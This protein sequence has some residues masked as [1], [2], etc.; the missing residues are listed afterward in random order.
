MKSIK[1]R[2]L[3]QADF[4][5]WIGGFSRSRITVIE[6]VHEC[7]GDVMF[8]LCL[9]CPCDN[10]WRSWRASERT[11]LNCY[12]TFL[13]HTTNI[14]RKVRAPRRVSALGAPNNVLNCHLDK[15][16]MDK[17]SQHECRWSVPSLNVVYVSSVLLLTLVHQQ[18]HHPAPVHHHHLYHHV[19]WK[20]E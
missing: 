13:D 3:L 20:K 12:H 4:A 6:Y 15:T 5:D 7:K 17:T 19:F 10:R 2:I 14:S 1:W 9:F 11:L 8:Y 18:L 16:N